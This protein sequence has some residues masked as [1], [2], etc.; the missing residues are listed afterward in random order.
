[1]LPGRKFSHLP[2]KHRPVLT[3]PPMGITRTASEGALSRRLGR[4]QT[5]GQWPGS[6]RAWS[7][8]PG[9]D[10]ARAFGA[11]AGASASSSAPCRPGR[12]HGY[13]CKAEI[14]YPASL[15][16]IESSNDPWMRQ[17]RELCGRAGK[18]PHGQRYK[19]F[20]PEEMVACLQEVPDTPGRRPKEEAPRP[21]LMPRGG[22][23]STPGSVC[24]S[25]ILEARSHPALCRWLECEAGW[26][27]DPQDADQVAEAA[28]RLKQDDE[29]GSGSVPALMDVSSSGLR[30]RLRAVPVCGT[31][32]C[33]YTVIHAVVSM[34]RV[35]RRDLWADRE[36][37]RRR[38]EEEFLR[39]REKD[40]LLDSMIANR[41]TATDFSSPQKPRPA[42]THRSLF[43]DSEVQDW[44]HRLTFDEASPSKSPST[45]HSPLRSS[46]GERTPSV[47]EDT[48]GRPR[49]SSSACSR[50]P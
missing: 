40:E 2:M 1:M 5:T 30:Y 20:S 16:D 10:G 31:C 38:R 8:N 9:G 46:P 50:R 41:R 7:P 6:G 32:F 23:G 28:Q 35:Q 13:Y 11:R 12:C 21:P 17:A 19:L 18:G 47:L 42:R 27:F 45:K 37:R 48:P 24:V 33:I 43:L 22:P 4:R 15:Q 44:L 14:R 34:I 25:W 39:E 3:L 29:A 49:R 36:Q 26:M